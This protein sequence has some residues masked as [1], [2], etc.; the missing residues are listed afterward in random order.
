MYICQNLSKKYDSQVVI[1]DFSYTFP[2]RGFVL[3]LGESGCGKTTLLN[4]LAGIVPYDEGKITFN[5]EPL[6][7]NMSENQSSLI[8]YIT[9]DSFFVD[10][11]SIIDNLRLVSNEDERIYNLLE[12]FNL[13][14]V[15][16]QFPK[17]LS[18]GERQRIS[19]IRMLL[20][21]KSVLLLDEPTAALDNQNKRNVFEVLQNLK[22]RV[23]I[24]CSSH[25]MQAIQYAD[26][27]IDF[28]ELHKYSKKQE[29]IRYEKRQTTPHPKR[30]LYN[31]IKQWFKGSS[32]EKSS[33]KRLAAIMIL[34]ILAVCLGDLPQNKI[35]SNAEYVYGLN[36][37][38]VTC[39]GDGKN[40]IGEISNNKD[41]KSVVLNYSAT[42]P[43]GIDRNDINSI[44]PTVDYNITAHTLPSNK[45]AFK[46]SDKL[47][48]GTYFTDTNQ[49]ML[50]MATAKNLGDPNLLIGSTY[51]IDM[52]GGK[53]DFEIVGIFEDFTKTELEYLRASNINLSENPEE[54]TETYF[55]NS[56]YTNQFLNDPN[57]FE[58][59]QST[60]C[61]YFSSF[62]AMKE[63]YDSISVHSGDATY[64]YASINP[65]LEF[66][67]EYLF[68]IFF[69]AAL[70][71]ICVAVFSYSQIIKVEAIHNSSSFSVFNYC[72]YSVNDIKKSWLKANMVQLFKVL[73]V[74]SV[75]AALFMILLNIINHYV[76]IIPFQI[77][78]FN[79]A[80][81]AV[82]VLLVLLSG[83]IS[84]VS[85]LKQIKI[86]GW[87]QILLTQRDLL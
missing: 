59:G 24:I 21:D 54:W 84:A 60:Y 74:S 15:A 45:E 42:V 44:T 67:F 52:Y 77:F 68:Y 46:L 40:I 55:I 13:L 32:Q 5:N 27:V 86:L 41:V 33:I 2:Q 8:G 66:A 83:I 51:T 22:N 36:Q 26:Q 25:D 70:V 16:E 58:Q 69:P 38:Q 7:P 78:T 34:T 18:G 19:I 9:Q 10:Y 37:L 76:V 47:A 61:I 30:K 3:L 23:L 57:F 49:I 35:D 12:E 4:M 29:I 63:F 28:H 87:H 85:S 50:T 65:E 79:Y 48:F 20:Q 64:I 81:V 6:H 72:G 71:I 43:D 17:Q 82:F 1:S 53:E 75:I 56:N 39:V 14:N 31:F 62:S 11:L 80:L 73:A